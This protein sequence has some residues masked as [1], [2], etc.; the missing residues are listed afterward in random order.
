M[1]G[2][3]CLVTE[4]VTH[5]VV[6][7]AVRQPPHGQGL[8]VALFRPGNLVASRLNLFRG[9]TRQ[10][11]DP[12]PQQGI[13][14]QL[15]VFLVLEAAD[16]AYTDARLRYEDAKTEFRQEGTGGGTRYVALW[17]LNSEGGGLQ[18]NS[19]PDTL[20]HWYEGVLL[21]GV[22]DS[23][24]LAERVV[25]LGDRTLTGRALGVDPEGAL[26]VEDERG[27]RRSIVAG[28]VMPLKS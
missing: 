17:L 8:Q 9:K 16:T 26:V 23:T 10:V 12:A 6:V 7:L 27:R 11:A 21:F 5:R 22:D 28:D 4:Q 2:R 25:E 15:P 3:L 13:V 18:W 24:A 20:Q 1:I 14:A 19:I